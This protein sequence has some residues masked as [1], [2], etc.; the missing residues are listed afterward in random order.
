MVCKL[1]C[2]YGSFKYLLNRMSILTDQMAFRMLHKVLNCLCIVNCIKFITR[3]FPISLTV[4]SMIIL[5]KKYKIFPQRLIM[6]LSIAAFF[7]AIGY[8]MVSLREITSPYYYVKYI[9]IHNITGRLSNWWWPST[10]FLCI[11]R[12]LVDIFWWEICLAILS[13]RYCV[14]F[15][16]LVL[17]S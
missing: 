17:F 9:H 16:R 8:V 6:Y 12:N 10:G 5:F 2:F 11:S 14:L 7:Q 13:T 1:W 3:A 4:V 15:H